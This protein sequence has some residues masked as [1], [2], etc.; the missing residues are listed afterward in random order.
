MRIPSKTQHFSLICNGKASRYPRA[1]ERR[2]AVI[3]HQA[4]RTA[5]TATGDNTYDQPPRR[6]SAMAVLVA[7]KAY[8]IIEFG[9]ETWKASSLPLTL[10]TAF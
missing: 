5:I 9:Q 2:E 4:L 6:N 10:A 8:Q 3:C 7:E 1:H